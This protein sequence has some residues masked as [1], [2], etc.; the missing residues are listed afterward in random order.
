MVTPF[1]GS[2]TRGLDLFF[3]VSVMLLSGCSPSVQQPPAAQ[4]VS[5]QAPQVPPVLSVNELMVD[6]IDDAGHTLWNVEQPGRAPKTD[7]EWQELEHHAAQLA[8]SGSLIALGGTG[9]A[10][11]GWAQSP[12]WT[13]YSR[14]MTVAGLAARD[15]AR[16]KNLEALVKANGQL[17]G[18]CES[19]H[20]TFKP[21]LPT[22]GISH[23]HQQ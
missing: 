20:K 21:D 22:Q 5:P 3:G 15:A 17:V 19:C 12:D 4:Q 6:W 18:V 23:Q 16:S 1:K 13:K 9:Q 8:A 2:R 7:A 11:P 10:D 14:E